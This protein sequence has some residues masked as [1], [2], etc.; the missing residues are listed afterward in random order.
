MQLRI[1]MPKENIL[2]PESKKLKHK[3][4]IFFISKSLSWYLK[5]KPYELVTCPSRGK[6][7]E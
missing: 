1:F 3:D 4:H 2:A 5:V 7:V 6:C